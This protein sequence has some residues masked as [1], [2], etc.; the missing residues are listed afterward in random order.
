[1]GEQAH[2]LMEQAPPRVEEELVLQVPALVQLAQPV[3]AVLLALA[4]EHLPQEQ[5]VF[6]A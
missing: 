1:M 5:V 4:V 6:Q 2:R 3:V